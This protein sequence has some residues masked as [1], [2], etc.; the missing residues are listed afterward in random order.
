MQSKNWAKQIT[1]NMQLRPFGLRQN[2][3]RCSGK[4][5]ICLALQ[6]GAKE[7]ELLLKFKEF[8][9]ICYSLKDWAGLKLPDLESSVYIDFC[10]GVSN[11]DKHVKVSKHK[12]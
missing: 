6:N 3:S 9:T 2:P 11:V 1:A 5:E 8:C 12:D 10:R 4:D 7:A